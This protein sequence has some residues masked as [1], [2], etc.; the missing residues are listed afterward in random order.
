MIPVAQVILKRK[1]MD[2]R[3]KTVDNQGRERELAHANISVP[4]GTPRNE[5]CITSPVILQP[6]SERY[7]P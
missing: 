2:K 7:G 4:A 1:N 5:I 3:R 6:L